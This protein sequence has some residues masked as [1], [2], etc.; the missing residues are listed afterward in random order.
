MTSSTTTPASSYTSRR[1]AS[2]N[3]SPGSQKPA[4]Q[5]N[6][7]DGQAFWRPR[8]IRDESVEMMACVVAGKKSCELG[9]RLRPNR[10]QTRHDDDRIRPTDTINWPRKVVGQP[11]ARCCSSRKTR[12]EGSNSC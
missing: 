4:R 8:R 10:E 7:P 6:M 11:P 2:S 5:E 9:E 1:T 3:D 12:T